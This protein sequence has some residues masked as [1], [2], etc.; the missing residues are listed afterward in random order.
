MKNERVQ[1]IC[2]I[3][4][5]IEVNYADYMLIGT[6]VSERHLNATFVSLNQ[7]YK[8]LASQENR[9]LA[10]RVKLG[11]ENSWCAIDLGRI[12]VHLFLPEIRAYYDLESLWTCGP[13]F[14]QSLI[15]FKRNKEDLE[16]RIAFIEVQDENPNK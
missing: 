3:D 1:D 10:N 13:E 6:C 14:D 12:V 8:K 7:Q 2:C 15:E 11:K 5:P 16:K 9:F 4:L